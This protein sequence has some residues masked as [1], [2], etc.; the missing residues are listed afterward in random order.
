[1]NVA[2]ITKENA[3][4]EGDQLWI[5]ENNKQ[6]PWWSEIDFRSGFLL[7]KLLLYKKNPAPEKLNEI[8]KATDIE[9]IVF[10]KNQ[11][12]L[13]LGTSSHFKNK[14]IL[15]WE[16]SEQKEVLEKIKPTVEG[17]KINSIRV[18]SDEKEFLNEI[19]TRLTASLTQISNVEKF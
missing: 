2:K 9:P 13:L 14:W 10:S 11:Q 15:L 8:S 17:L 1:M 6:N 3:F 7:S 19:S 16:K 4:S 5:L 18:F 12:P